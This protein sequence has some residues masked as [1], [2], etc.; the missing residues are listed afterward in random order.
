MTTLFSSF[1]PP[2]SRSPWPTKADDVAVL[3]W[4]W[5]ESVDYSCFAIIYIYIYKYIHT[6]Y[7]YIDMNDNVGV[8]P[9]QLYEPFFHFK[10]VSI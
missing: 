7:I 6:H 4:R 10:D 8:P 2:H 1:Y 5:R 3:A 9:V